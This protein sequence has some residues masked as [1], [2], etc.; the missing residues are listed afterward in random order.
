MV[1]HSAFHA[2]IV[3][4]TGGKDN[5]QGRLLTSDLIFSILAL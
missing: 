3:T 5:P 4:K 2:E 1:G